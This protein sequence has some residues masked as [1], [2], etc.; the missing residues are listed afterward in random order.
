MTIKPEFYL[1]INNHHLSQYSIRNIV[2][3]TYSPSQQTSARTNKSA[4]SRTHCIPRPCDLIPMSE[5]SAN[6]VHLFKKYYPF[7]DKYMD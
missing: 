2:R 3:N 6:D 1:F 7:N 5:V 4:F